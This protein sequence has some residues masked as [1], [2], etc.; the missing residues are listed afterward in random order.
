MAPTSS[1]MLSVSSTGAWSSMDLAPSATKAEIEMVLRLFDEDMNGFVTVEEFAARMLQI[2]KERDE[3][4]TPAAA[5]A[6]ISGRTRG[7]KTSASLSKKREQARE[8][9]RGS[10]PVRHVRT[11]FEY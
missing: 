3:G 10:G 11:N 7:A 9:K 6:A 4:R 8:K 2:Q 1:P 5:A